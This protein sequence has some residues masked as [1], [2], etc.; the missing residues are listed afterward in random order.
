MGMLTT[1]QV[2]RG[3]VVVLII[4]SPVASA[5]TPAALA[6]SLKELVD[7]RASRLYRGK[8][9]SDV[10]TMT[11]ACSG[12]HCQSLTPFARSPVRAP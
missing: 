8:I 4:P 12:A 1:P 2:A 6:T 11:S 3:R 10:A 5:P 9:T 7:D